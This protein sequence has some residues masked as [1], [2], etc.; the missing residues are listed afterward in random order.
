MNREGATAFASDQ[1]IWYAARYRPRTASGAAATA[2]TWAAGLWIS[3][4]R[5]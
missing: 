1:D 2:S 3:S 5:V 4:P